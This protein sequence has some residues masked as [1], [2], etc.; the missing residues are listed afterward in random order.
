MTHVIFLID[1]NSFLHKQYQK[2]ADE[3]Y[4]EIELGCFES[5]VPL[6]QPRAVRMQNFL[7]VAEREAAPMLSKNQ[8]NIL[9]L[10]S[11]GASETEIS[12]AMQLSYAGIRHHIDTLKKKFS[13]TTREE[14]IAVYCQNYRS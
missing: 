13:V 2:S 3:L 9:E 7:M 10:L 1:E 5:P 6:K 14:L 4:R 12:R 8:A 11:M